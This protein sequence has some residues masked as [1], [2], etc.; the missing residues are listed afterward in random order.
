MTSIQ[1][2]LQEPVWHWELDQNTDEWMEARAGRIT[3]SMVKT[4]LVNGKDPSGFGTG[5]IT[6]LYRLIEERVTGEIR[7]SFGNGYTDYGHDM[8]D[9][10][11]DAYEVEH[12]Q[13]LQRVG[14][15]SLGDHLGCSPDRVIP[16][17]RRGVEIKCYPVNHARILDSGTHGKDEYI[18]CQFSMFV[19]GWED[20]DLWYWHPKLR[21]ALYSF[22]PDRTLFWQFEEAIDRFVGLMNQKLE[23]EW[24]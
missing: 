20:W 9:F 16:K 22:K 5:A 17:L 7:E 3:A 10:A 4:L 1:A 19:T 13:R 21:P 12:F 24:K 6:E 8:E 14:F 11:A 15:V 23:K 18:Q 2:A